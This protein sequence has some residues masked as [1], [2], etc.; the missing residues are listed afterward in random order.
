[1]KELELTTYCHPLDLVSGL[2]YCVTSDKVDYTF[3]A[4]PE[5]FY[6]EEIIDLEKLGY[7][8]SHGNYALFKLVKKDIDTYKAIGLLAKELGIPKANIVYLGLKDKA[9]TTTQYIAINKNIIDKTYV[10]GKTHKIAHDLVIEFVGYTR[11]K[12]RKT[13][14][15][16]NK[17]SIII[18]DTSIK[19]D[20]EKI[21]NT[22]QL[23][24]LPSYYGYQRF[25]VKR[26]NTHLIGKY[27]IQGR[28]S[29]ALWEILYSIYP[30]E[31]IESIKSRI[32]GEF[33]NKQFYEKR[34]HEIL[35]RK[36]VHIDKVLSIIDNR[37]FKLLIEA[38]QTYLFNKALNNFIEVNG[39]IE[40]Q[41]CVLGPKC[42]EGIEYYNLV[43]EG[44]DTRFY[45]DRL[46]TYGLKGFTR[47]TLFKL[48]DVKLHVNDDYI[49]LV[50]TLDKGLYASIVLRE[51]FKEN[52]IL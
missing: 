50:F 33:T 40:K 31:S 52:L 24:G 25:G 17:F 43:D 47:K 39:L 4:T 38:Y 32:K 28:Y 49:K 51:I 35:E 18:R 26:Y 36:H 15:L 16:G 1:M 23:H 21:I 14:L 9:A 44:I 41:V 48:K 46:S 8:P 34:I 45:I 42:I 30:S 22:I 3:K 10:S 19:E 7:S 12:P 2:K 11:I 6:V 13:H 29:E 37:F 20:L 5:T 27:I